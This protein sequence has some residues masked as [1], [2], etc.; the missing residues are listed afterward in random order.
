MFLSLPEFQKKC[1]NYHSSTSIE[2]QTQSYEVCP[3]CLTNFQMSWIS[4]YTLWND[5]P[6]IFVPIKST[7][8]ILSLISTVSKGTCFSVNPISVVI[9]DGFPAQVSVERGT[10]RET[11]GEHRW[12]FAWKKIQPFDN[13]RSLK[14]AVFL[15]IMHF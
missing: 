12:K 9:T 5:V 14:N 13:L 7:Y 8:L 3:I 15:L 10:P 1:M 2:I 4:I 6:T 11:F